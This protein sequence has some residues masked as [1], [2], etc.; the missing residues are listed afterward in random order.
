MKFT[1]QTYQDEDGNWRLKMLSG[2]MTH[3]ESVKAMRTAAKMLES[4][5]YDIGVSSSAKTPYG[6][7]QNGR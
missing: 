1:Y 7:S 2:P 4:D 5:E 6:H 3:D